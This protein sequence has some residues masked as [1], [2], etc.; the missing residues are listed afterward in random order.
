MALWIYT[1]SRELPKGDSERQ[2]N[3]LW[4]V[5]TCSS[6]M[7]Y[8]LQ[9]LF[10]CY[11]A[12]SCHQWYIGKFFCSRSSQNRGLFSQDYFN[13][14]TLAI[15]LGSRRL[16][17][18]DLKGIWYKFVLQSR[19]CL[20]RPVMIVD[21]FIKMLGA[22]TLIICDFSLSLCSLSLSVRTNSLLSC[23]YFFKIEVIRFI[24][25]RGVSFVRIV[26]V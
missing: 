20:H 4:C 8:C 17:I 18:Y 22:R 2:T 11:R 13:S 25:I 5:V 9:I 10:T 14:G 3:T 24:Y 1:P 26:Y 15:V 7:F 12:I 16:S 21:D 19:F 6:Y 23:L